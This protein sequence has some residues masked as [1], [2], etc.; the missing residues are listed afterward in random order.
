MFSKITVPLDGSAL[1]EGILDQVEKL[2]H[3]QGGK[4]QLLRVAFP[5]SLPGV[6]TE[7]YQLKH[8]RKAEEYLEKIAADMERKGLT[9]STHV[10]SGN[11]AEEILA[12]AERYS[13]VI[14]M[15]THGGGGF[16]RWAMGSVA[17]KVIRRSVKPVL[18]I[19]A[20]KTK[21]EKR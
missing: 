20:V 6:E 3:M 17:D 4:I 7:E 18:L 16:S 12:H 5:A 21:E 10:R 8:V 14:V 2:A 13:S 15:T 9:V 1:A 11:P 19:R